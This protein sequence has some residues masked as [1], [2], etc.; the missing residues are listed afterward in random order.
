MFCTNCGKQQ[1]EGAKFC[2]DCGSPMAGS[3]PTPS[4][5]PAPAPSAPINQPATSAPMP[6]S[7]PLAPVAPISEPA[8]SAQYVVTP[9]ERSPHSWVAALLL[10]FFLGSI[11]IHRFYVGK[12]GTG[13][14]M[15]FTLGGFGIW[16]LVDFIMICVGSFRD[17]QGRELKP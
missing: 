12:V 7:A 11:G 9:G 17:I 15:I 1:A 10:C 2:G 3:A 5:A 4:A 16:T 14:A 13:I 8:T 6:T